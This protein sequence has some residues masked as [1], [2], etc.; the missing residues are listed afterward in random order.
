MS[1]L[2]VG[3]PTFINCLS[4][5]LSKTWTPTLIWICCEF[6]MDMGSLQFLPPRISVFPFCSDLDWSY[7]LTGIIEYS[8]KQWSPGTRDQLVPRTSFME[9]NFSMDLRGGDGLRMI[10]IHCIYC[11]FCCCYISSTSYYQ[12]LDPGGWRP[13]L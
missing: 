13:L 12:A 1:Y 11:T 9:D 2:Q 7:G 6:N 8:L 10:Q 4:Y 5:D 3:V